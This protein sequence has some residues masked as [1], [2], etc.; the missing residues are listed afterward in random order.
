MTPT[1]ADFMA[2]ALFHAA[3]G[4]GR[5]SPNPMVGAVVVSAD[6][7]VVGQGYHA[8][9]GDAHAEVHALDM[10]GD[11]ARGGT[12]YC[13][14]EPC[15]HTGRTGPCTGAIIDAGIARVV[16]GL[17][18]PARHASGK[19]L[20]A[21]RRAGLT[22]E[23][24]LLG[25]EA[26]AVHEHY[27]HHVQT[28]R[29]YVTLKV[30]A[31][32]DGRIAVRSGDSRWISGE[33]SRADAH[34]LR[35]RHHGVAVG[36]GTVLADDP[37]LDV[38]HVEGTDPIPVVFD[39]R[40]RL[41]KHVRKQVLR[42]GTLVLH[43]EG[44]AAAAVRAI[45]ATGATP[46]AIARDRDG[47]VDVTRALVELGRRELRSLLV[48]GG[49]ALHG[50][51]VAAA[52]WQQLVVYLAPRLLGEG[53]PMLAGVAWDRVA[54]APGLELASLSRLGDDVRCVWLPAPRSGGS[55]RARRPRTR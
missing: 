6:G 15:C 42:P 19:G 35:A 13:T 4:R 45:A 41:A 51:F 43:G 28:A 16:V 39:T 23:L 14:L 29:P 10:A 2:R 30:A 48:E 46:I 53:T 1:D 18:D 49:G 8:R 25:D 44:V 50:A 27:V 47:H 26:A 40:L 32:V 22:V 17:R 3:R 37:R 12:L 55:T 5:T 52:A 36:V 20:A 7:L 21:L 11:R 24:G 38:R 34:L 9:A 31:S 33:A 54:A